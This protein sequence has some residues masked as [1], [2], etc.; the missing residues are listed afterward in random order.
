MNK[1]R[2]EPYA[3]IKKPVELLFGSSADTTQPDN[4]A[5]ASS[6]IDITK[7]KLP[8]SQPRRY[9]DPQNLKNYHAQLKN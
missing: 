5:N 9:F 4:Q 3:A 2:N 1:K 8:S 7:I 6:T